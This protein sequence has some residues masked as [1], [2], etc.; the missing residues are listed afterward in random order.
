MENTQKV[1]R[2]DK[3]KAAQRWS[4]NNYRYFNNYYFNLFPEI[5]KVV[6]EKSQNDQVEEAITNYFFDERLVYELNRFY[7]Q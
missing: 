7:N 4:E 2:L 5:K 6:E 1:Y 3:E